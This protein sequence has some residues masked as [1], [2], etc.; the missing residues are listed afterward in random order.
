MQKGVRRLEAAAFPLRRVAIGTPA[1]PI[2]GQESIAASAA[3][4]TL[5]NNLAI[6]FAGPIGIFFADDKLFSGVD[7]IVFLCEDMLSGAPDSVF[8]RAGDTFTRRGRAAGLALRAARRCQRHI[9]RRMASWRNSVK[10]RGVNLDCVI[11]TECVDRDTAGELLRAAEQLMD[12][13]TYIIRV[14]PTAGHTIDSPV[15]A[16][17]SINIHTEVYTYLVAPG[18]QP[19]TESLD[20]VS[21]AEKAKK[22]LD[23]ACREVLNTFYGDETKKSLVELAFPDKSSQFVANYKDKA[24]PHVKIEFKYSADI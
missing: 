24:P 18:K 4:I 20:A 7:R 23:N 3:L 16:E 12:T 19:R 13:P 5:C 2:E 14:D 22:C 21:A 1:G 17:V 8:L 11:C 10:L 6:N 9:A 15:A